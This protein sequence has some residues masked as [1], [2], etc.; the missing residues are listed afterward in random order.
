MKLTSEGVDFARFYDYTCNWILKLSYGMEMFAFF[1]L[2]PKK[3][4]PYQIQNK[5]EWRVW[6]W[7]VK[8]L[9]SILPPEVELLAK[10]EPPKYQYFRFGIENKKIKKKLRYLWQHK[11]CLT[12]WKCLLFSFYY[13]RNSCHI[14]Y[15]IKL[16]VLMTA[17]M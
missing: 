10:Y 3:F 12:G 15:K 8:L 17:V 2:L 13:Q 1:I 11:N 6:S 14:K 5:I 4:M 16:N 7:Q 9:P